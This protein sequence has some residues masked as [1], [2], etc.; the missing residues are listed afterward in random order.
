[1]SDLR[2]RPATRHAATLMVLPE[3]DTERAAI[4]LDLGASDILYAPV[5]TQELAIRIRAQLD[6]KRQG[7]QAARQPPRGPGTGRDRQPDGAAQPAL[8][9]LPVAADDGRPGKGV[10]VMMLDLDHF[11]GVNDQYGHAAGDEVLRRLSQRLR[12]EMRAGDLWRASGVRSCSSPFRTPITTPRGIVPNVCAAASLRRP[13]PPATAAVDRR[14]HVRGLA[15]SDSRPE[16]KR[17]NSARARRPRALQCQVAGPRPGH[18]RRRG[19]PPDRRSAVVRRPERPF[20]HSP[21]VRSSR[22]ATTARSAAHHAPAFPEARRAPAP[23]ARLPPR[24]SGPAHGPPPRLSKGSLSSAC[25]PPE[26][27]P[28]LRAVAAQFLDVGLD[29][30]A[31]VVT[32]IARQHQREGA[33][34]E[35]AD[36]RRLAGI[37]CGSAPRPRQGPPQAG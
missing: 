5:D 24:G 22:S 29:P 34:A 9:P 17:R 26:A 33:E 4:A 23:E 37:R 25:A 14:Y 8:W 27:A 30:P 18:L 31:H 6:R 19:P 35:R 28:D 11:K 21:S 32:R 13:S 12:A 2:S 36:R 7:R 15:L 3:G 20:G 10:A 16:W 1:L